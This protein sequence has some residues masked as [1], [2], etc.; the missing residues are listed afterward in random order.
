MYIYNEGVVFG[1]ASHCYVI[2][3]A[4]QPIF[5]IWVRACHKL[6]PESIA[7]AC[8]NTLPT[9]FGHENCRNKNRVVLHVVIHIY[10]YIYIHVYLNVTY[11]YTP[12]HVHKNNKT[13][14]IHI[15][16]YIY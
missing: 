15:Y 14:H 12:I 3:P 16:I 6:E 9:N 5:V 11:T 2:T 4:W 8:S 7:M 1:L 13:T 10:I